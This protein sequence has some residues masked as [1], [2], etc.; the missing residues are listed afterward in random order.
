MLKHTALAE[1]H[2]ELGGKL[3][4]FSGWAMPVNYGSQIEEHHAVRKNAGMFDV[5]HMTV[6][7]VIGSGTK[8]F[9]QYVLAND[10]AKLKN[11]G[12]ALYTAMLNEHG[13]VID[14]LIVYR[15]SWG[16]RLVVNCA[17]RE[18]DLQWL[19]THVEAFD[20]TLQERP[21]LAM[22]AVQGPLARE[23][24][25]QILSDA[26][27]QLVDQLGVF[28]ACELEGE[29]SGWF[30]G[31]TGYTGEDGFE[32]ILP[33]EQAVDTWQALR[34]VGVASCGL[35]ARDTLRLEAGMNLYGHEMNEQI[36][37]LRANMAW[38]VALEPEREFIGR[39]AL[40]EEKQA[41]VEQKLV[42]LVMHSR[43]VI[44]DGYAVQIPGGATQGIVTS[45]TFSPTLG[46]SIALARVPADTGEQAEVVIR[47]KQV[48]VVVVPPCFVR[49][50]QAVVTV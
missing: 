13:G 45:G 9:L 28:S 8:S 7:D 42:G 6:L 41:G 35:G 20:V 3:V 11:D 38:T 19:E 47:N 14:D 23:K 50:G 1:L 27:R 32:I 12:K 33:A 46:V 10:V 25:G 17:T 29:K 21:E 39:A 4:D 15:M 2:Q 26:D 48:P 5:S 24:F 40:M 49:K 31:R 34:S 37:P 16:Y 30:V 44:R 22:I 36:S 18:K 43:G